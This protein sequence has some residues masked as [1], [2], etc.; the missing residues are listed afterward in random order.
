MLGIV[1]RELGITPNERT[2]LQQT[3]YLCVVSNRVV[4]MVT[5]ECID[6]AYLLKDNSNRLPE[7]HRAMLG[8]H[9]MWVHANFRKQGIATR[10]VDTARSKMVFGITVPS[11]LLA[12]SSPTEAGIR[13]GMRYMQANSEAD[14]NSTNQLLI[15]DCGC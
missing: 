7:A 6:T 2:S 14:S 5:T 12:F 4:A 10:L 13:F 1:E 3:A 9:R 8:I 11:S 15:Y